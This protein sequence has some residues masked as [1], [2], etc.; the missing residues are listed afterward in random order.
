MSTDVSVGTL[1]A[2][3]AEIRAELSDLRRN[4]LDRTTWNDRMKTVEQNMFLLQD[5]IDEL[6]TKQ[7]ADREAP[8]PAAG[9]PNPTLRRV[10]VFSADERVQR[11]YRTLFP[12]TSEANASA[13]PVV[14]RDPTEGGGPLA[15][16]RD[17]GLLL[18]FATHEDLAHLRTRLEALGVSTSEVLAGADRMLLY[19]RDPAGHAVGLYRERSGRQ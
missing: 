16:E 10:L 5:Q 1:A 7:G 2:Q 3:L 13:V 12:E 18:W 11:F 6:F 15:S 8:R 4:T 17:G 9:Y 14:I 19:T